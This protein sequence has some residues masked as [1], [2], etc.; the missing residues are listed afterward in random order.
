MNLATLLEISAS[1][2][3]ERVAIGGIAGGLTYSA[4]L[5]HSKRL[6]ASLD[7]DDI[8]HVIFLGTNS[9][10]TW[11]TL[12]AA[13]FVNK[14]YI[15]LNYRLTDDQ[16]GRLLVRSAPAAVV[17]DDEMR[18][19]LV[20]I[21][22][23][24]IIPSVD[25]I[26][27]LGIDPIARS[28]SDEGVAVLLFT[29]GTT[30][31]PK[32]AILTH[33]N[34]SSYVLE[35]TEF[36]GAAEEECAL[37]SVPP[38]HIASISAA[39]TGTYMGRRV[40]QLASFDAESWVDLAR[41]ERVTH[42]M[43]VPTMLSR[44]LDILSSLGEKLPDLRHLSYG[45]GKMPRPIIEKALSTLPHVDFVNAYGL[46]ET[47]S[48]IA[49]LTP[50]DHRAAAA[51]SQIEIRTR[52][53]SV[54]RPLSSVELEIRDPSGARVSQGQLGEIFVRGAQVS[55]EYLERSGGRGGWFATRDSG[56][57]D[58]EG[59][60]FLDGRLDDVIVRGGENI[61]PGEI[62]AALDEHPAV[63]QTAVVGFPHAEWGEGICAFVVL[64]AGQSADEGELKGWVRDR[65][66][67]ARRPERVL[68][69]RELPYSETGKLLRRVLRLELAA[70]AL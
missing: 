5:A 3:G 4:L 45:G 57:Q 65:L 62:E 67:S 61:S 38:Y 47:S 53:S 11:V 21:D 23:L 27:D 19:R 60:L 26:A 41:A 2:F 13:A 70:E 16:L 28:P 50:E 6:A 43:V 15:P 49:L 52:L 22:S 18:H 32:T 33:N 54:G 17:I 64:K 63:A 44:I 40:V 8:K 14:P 37:V 1:A 20:A 51:S 48:T 35:T 31:E 25:V 34:L 46:T 29:S 69:V 59:Y 56:Y 68:F 58:A 9:P 66:R 12:F 55:G 42:A 36:M 7:R 30:G 10:A 39:L 24:E